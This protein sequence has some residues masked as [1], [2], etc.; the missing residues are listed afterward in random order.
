MKTRRFFYDSRVMKRSSVSATAVRAGGRSGLCGALS[1]AALLLAFAASPVCAD[2]AD[3]AAEQ[4]AV[5]R[6]WIQDR[7]TG[8]AELVAVREPDYTLWNAQRIRDYEESLKADSAPPLGILTIETLGIQVPVYN[9]TSD[10]VLNRGAG[11][12]KGMGRMHGDG[13][14]AISGHRDGIFRGLK[15][16]QQG[17]DILVQTPQGVETY[18]VAH[19][20]IV[21]KE[22]VSVLKRFNEKAL[23]LVTCYPFYFVGHAPKRFIVTAFPRSDPP[24]E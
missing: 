2:T 15:D 11:R 17:D 23:T 19:I 18:A 5:S 6:I 12:I 13:N 8:A 9:G 7:F 22:E 4:P 14:L 24:E 10:F 16:I 1:F 21:P 20:D 3:P